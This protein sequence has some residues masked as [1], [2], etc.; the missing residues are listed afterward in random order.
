M[1]RFNTPAVARGP[2]TTTGVTGT[3]F[4][5]AAGHGR[6]A[7][8]ELFL[9]SVSNFNEDQFYE[10]AGDRLARMQPLIAEIATSDPT[11]LA[12]LVRWL[13]NSANL[14]S[15]P[16]AI[17]ADAVHYRLAGG[18]HGGNRQFVTD[19]VARPDEAAEF[20]AYWT[21]QHGRKVPSAVKRGISDVMND[22]TEYGW[23]KW[24]GKAKRGN[25]SLADVLNICHP[26]PKD[27]RQEALFAAIMADA[28]SREVDFAEMV[29][30]IVT[31]GSDG[32][33]V[34]VQR[35]LLPMYQARLE[36]HSAEVGEQRRMLRDPEFVRRAGITHEVAA[37]AIGRLTATDWAALIPNMGFQALL[38]NLRRFDEAGIDTRTRYIVRDRLRDPE[39]VRK[40]K[41]YPI[42]FLS[43][44]RN[45]PLE[46]AGDLEVAA[47]LVLDNVP[48][49]PGKTLILIDRSASMAAQ[50]SAKGTLRR[51]DA[52]NVFGAA[53][54]LRAENADL[55]AF[56]TSAQVIPFRKGE[57]L[58]RLAD[59]P[60]NM[61]GTNTHDAIAHHYRDHSRV[62]VL[63]DEQA[64]GGTYF[65]WATRP[66]QSGDVFTAVPANVPCFTWNLAGYQRGHAEDGK[67]RFT[68]GGLSD[69]GMNLIVP[70]ERGI[71][72]RWPWE[73]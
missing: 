26:K 50:M 18:F 66:Y 57:S 17:A 20:L 53:L 21:S 43:A 30:T 11:W 45:A 54:A 9:A 15:V 71:S 36:F 2:I 73:N 39:Q 56:G 69:I 19:A 33:S 4:E 28:Y 10:N 44:Y 32:E 59:V 70:L 34:E 67:K 60:A 47:N 63:T 23:L 62:I 13:R 5:G 42:R 46:Y 65:N 48:S 68:F 16:T 8:S 14:R 25:Y 64:H 49:L 51:V 12:G 1:A 22:L 6:D 7:K 24:K 61:G 27:A 37:G 55:V 72:Q 40:S 38:M 29:E 41:M 31:A 3:T 35:P 58:L 52:A